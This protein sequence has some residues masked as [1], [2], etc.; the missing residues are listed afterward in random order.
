ME[1]KNQKQTISSR[2]ETS[3]LDLLR[4]QLRQMPLQLAAPVKPVNSSRV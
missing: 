3:L 2:G 1:K 4:L